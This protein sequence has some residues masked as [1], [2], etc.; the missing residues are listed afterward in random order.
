MTIAVA[1]DISV[2]E[3]KPEQRLADLLASFP[4]AAL[5]LFK[6]PLSAGYL[7]YNLTH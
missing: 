2:A 1:K 6:Q 3:P 7:I 5:L 4:M